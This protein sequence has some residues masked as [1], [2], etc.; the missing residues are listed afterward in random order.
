MS[1]NLQ[2][3]HFQTEKFPRRRFFD[4][5]IRW[6]RIDFE[7]ESEAAKKFRIGNH[8]SSERMATDRAAKPPLDLGNI[9]DVIDVAVGKQQKLEIGVPGSEPFASAIGRV[10]QNRPIG[11]VHQIAIRFKNAAAKALVSHRVSL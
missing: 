5:E 4:Q 6:H 7:L 1:T 9:L 8:R 2:Y 11:R 10:E 3:L